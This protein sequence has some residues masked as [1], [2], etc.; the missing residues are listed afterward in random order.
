MSSNMMTAM[1]N[2]L[3]GM[4]TVFLV[5]IFISLIISLFVY[6]PGLERRLKRLGRR[7]GR[8]FSRKEAAQADNNRVVPQRPKLSREELYGDSEDSDEEEPDEGALIAVIMAAIVASEGGAVSADQLRVRS[9]RRVGR[10]SGRAR[11]R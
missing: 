4:G 5:L 3:M 2:T 8:M 6:I 1:L 10:K 9:I 11:R 7:L